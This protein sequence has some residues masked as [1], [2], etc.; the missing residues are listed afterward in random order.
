MAL[1]RTWLI[2]ILTCIHYPGQ[3]ASRTRPNSSAARYVGRSSR[4]TYLPPHFSVPLLP[5][6]ERTQDSSYTFPELARPLRPLWIT[7]ASARFPY[8]V[9]DASFSPVICVSAASRDSRMCKV[10]EMTMDYGDR[11]TIFTFPFHLA[12]NDNVVVY[13]W[14]IHSPPTLPL[15]ALETSHRIIGVLTRGPRG[16]CQ[17]AGYSRARNATNFR[18]RRTTCRSMEHVTNACAESSRSRAALYHY[19]ENF[20]RA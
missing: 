19:H 14:V 3:S 2:R 12:P 13:C 20:Q 18:R 11:Y 16:C 8:I 4:R 10:L 15:Y 17:Q 1:L 6:I 5:P 7:P 9:P